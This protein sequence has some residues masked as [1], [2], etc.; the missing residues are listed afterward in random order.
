MEKLRKVIFLDIDGVL[1]PLSANERFKHNLKELR[2]ELAKNFNNERYLELNEY[3]LGAVY[4][5]WDQ[6][7]IANLKKLISETNAEIVISSSWRLQSS[8]EK[9]RYLFKI[10]DLDGFV[11]DQTPT[12]SDSRNTEISEFLESNKDITHFVILDDIDFS[13]HFPKQFVHTKIYFDD[14]CY[15]KSLKI[16]DGLDYASDN[17]Q[18][19]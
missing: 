12:S 6:K 7:A 11:K 9:L 10:H 17:K 5:D 19:P 4:Y 14:Q 13:R 3:D 8:L 1:Q 18:Q 16:L 15:K 2:K